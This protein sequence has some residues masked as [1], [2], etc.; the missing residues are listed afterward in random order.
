MANDVESKVAPHPYSELIRQILDLHTPGDE[1]G[2][3]S[4]GVTVPCPTQRLIQ[5]ELAQAEAAPAT[6]PAGPRTG[7]PSALRITQSEPRP[8]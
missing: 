3:P 4:C 7:N 6:E 2:C 5:R 8:S 1:P